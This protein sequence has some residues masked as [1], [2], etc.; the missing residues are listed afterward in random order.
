MINVDISNVWGEIS[1]PDL[2]G[3]EAEVFDAHNALVEGT[4][5]GSLYRGWLK[6]AD[7]ENVDKILDAAREIR[8]DSQV[9][10]VLGTDGGCLGAEGAIELLQGD[11]QTRV[12]FAGNSFSQGAWNRL[13]RKLEGKDLSLC[14]VSKSGE[15]LETMVAFRALRWY[16]ERKYGTEEAQQRIYVISGENTPLAAMA[17]EEGWMAF[18]IPENVSGEFSLLSSAGLLPMAVAGLDIRAILA[19]AKE[20]GEEYNLRSYENPVWQY[21]AVRELMSRSGK[22]VEL[23]Q[24]GAPEFAGLAR[25]WQQLFAFRGGLY[26]AG[27]EVA[28]SRNQLGQLL[29]G[30]GGMI[31]ATQLRFTQPEG[32][33][34]ILGDV[35][36][37]D[38]LNYLE[39]KTLAMLEEGAAGI[40]LEAQMDA[41]TGVVSIRC[42]EEKE[43][44]LGKLIWFFQLSACL[45]A[46]LRGA[47]P[48]GREEVDKMDEKLARGLGKPAPE[49]E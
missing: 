8:E 36:D 25:W 13:L 39:G 41:G 15:K 43:R 2:L 33:V 28:D 34:Q 38:G 7:T 31:F 26:P 45:S 9:L 30:S 46:Y 4:A 6:L 21:A 5:A 27:V 18:P 37:L 16:L 24:Y 3:L 19:G 22:A 48:Y 49:G 29:S 17:Q 23:L 42:A 32:N 1:L 40:F 14:A 10:V 35:K 47:D 44:T 12:L 11:G 20:A